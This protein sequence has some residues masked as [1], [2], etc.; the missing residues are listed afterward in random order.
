MY[1]CHR[2]GQVLPRSCANSPALSSAGQQP[3]SSTTHEMARGRPTGER[4]QF[5]A[6]CLQMKSHVFWALLVKIL[7]WLAQPGAQYW[8]CFKISH[9]FLWYSQ[10]E[11]PTTGPQR[12]CSALKNVNEPNDVQ[13][14]ETFIEGTDLCLTLW[15]WGWLCLWLKSDWQ[16]T[17]GSC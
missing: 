8:C 13:I 7:F 15:K 11:E 14:P 9:L 16:L 2:Q 10:G 3:L 1:L 17:H 6:K 4:R 5:L 12:E